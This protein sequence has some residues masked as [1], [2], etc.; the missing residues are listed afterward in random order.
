MLTRAAG[1][2]CR[3][4]A[5]AADRLQSQRNGVN[6]KHPEAV[7]SLDEH[8]HASAGQFVTPQSQSSRV[9]M[10][11]HRLPCPHTFCLWVAGGCQPARAA[12]NFVSLQHNSTPLILLCCACTRHSHSRG[13]APQ[14]SVVDPPSAAN[15]LPCPNQRVHA[16]LCNHR[17]CCSAVIV[18]DQAEPIGLIMQDEPEQYLVASTQRSPLNNRLVC[19]TSEDQIVSKHAKPAKPFVK[20]CS[21]A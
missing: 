10:R 13:T 21:P 11:Q 12:S 6:Y 17:T 3:A 7:K 14:Q 8:V 9:Q 18:N 15:P 2:G 4:W 5:P 16:A 19:T 1:T 20:P